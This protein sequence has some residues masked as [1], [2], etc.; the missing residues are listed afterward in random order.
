M[1]LAELSRNQVMSYV[2]VLQQT[3]VPDDNTVPGNGHADLI[4]SRL[5]RLEDR[6]FPCIRLFAQSY[7]PWDGSTVGSSFAA[8]VL[9][10]WAFFI[11]IMHMA[12]IPAQKTVRARRHNAS[13]KPAVPV[14][15]K[16]LAISIFPPS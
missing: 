3:L 11:T 10:A 15:P 9:G 12:P 16:I 14:T 6:L 5:G 1:P 4:W 8:I 13:V 2:V 7:S